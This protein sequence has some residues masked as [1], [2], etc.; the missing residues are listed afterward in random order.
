MRA[1]ICSDY[2]RKLRKLIWVT[3]NKLGVSAGI[4]EPEANLHVTYHVDGTY[5]HKM[6]HRGKPLKICSEK[7]PPLVSI[8]SKEQLL[9]TATFYTDD[10]MSRLAEFTPDGR[11][12]TIVVLGQSVFTN[13]RC[14]AFNSFILHRDHEPSLFVDSYRSYEDKSFMLISVNVFALDLFPNHKVAMI[15]YKG[16]EADEVRP[17]EGSP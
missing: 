6:I 11:A 5:H 17:P 13:V 15:V 14:A 1:I 2:S 9:G 16:R 3:E 10:T 8:A 12:D 4:C 7:K